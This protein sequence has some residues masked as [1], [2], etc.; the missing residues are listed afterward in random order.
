MSK[1]SELLYPDAGIGVVLMANDADASAEQT[2]AHMAGSL[3][4]LLA[5]LLA[6][7]PPL[8]SISMTPI[9]L[10]WIRSSRLSWGQNLNPDTDATRHFVTSAAPT[11]LVC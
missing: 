7:Q 4:G 6:Q 10:L 3:A 2:R 11:M 8:R 1:Y 9:C 5:N